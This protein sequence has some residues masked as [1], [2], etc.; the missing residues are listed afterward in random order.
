MQRIVTIALPFGEGFADVTGY[1]VPAKVSNNR[2]EPDDPADFEPFK[3]VVGGV[4]VTEEMRQATRKG[5][6]QHDWITWYVG[7][8]FDRV[9]A[10]CEG[11]YCD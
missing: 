9:V 8:N 10:Q 11:D 5:N 6:Q 4:D 2:D 7:V 3:I 1:Y